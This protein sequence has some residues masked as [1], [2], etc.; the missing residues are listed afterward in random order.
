MIAVLARSVTQVLPRLNPPTAPFEVALLLAKPIAKKAPP[1][2]L[3][4]PYRSGRLNIHHEAMED[5]EHG[6]LPSANPM[7]NVVYNTYLLRLCRPAPLGKVNPAQLLIGGYCYV[8]RNKLA[9][10]D[11]R[12]VSNSETCAF[13]MLELNNGNERRLQA[14]FHACRLRHAPPFS[15]GSTENK[16]RF[17]IF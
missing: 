5:P 12:H 1:L 16:S 17:I 7:Q 11:Y 6:Y 14:D 8:C 13:K 3:A 2:L 10:V 4:I 9:M 15:R